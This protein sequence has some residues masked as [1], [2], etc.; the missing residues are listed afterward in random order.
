MIQRGPPPISYND[1]L[2]LFVTAANDSASQDNGANYT[3]LCEVSNSE[4]AGELAAPASLSLAR[5]SQLASGC[6]RVWIV[7]D[8][9]EVFVF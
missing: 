9:C 8:R 3:S 2:A 7:L 6:I 1:F 5:V 4:Q